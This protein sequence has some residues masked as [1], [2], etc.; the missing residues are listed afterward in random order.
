M[1]LDYK[2][3][4]QNLHAV[5]AEI[6]ILLDYSLIDNSWQLGALGSL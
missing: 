2:E 1:K 3:I 4:K 5:E 6:D